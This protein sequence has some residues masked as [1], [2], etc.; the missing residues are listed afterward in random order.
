MFA[1][2]PTHMQRIS[3]EKAAAGHPAASAQRPVAK[4]YLF[5]VDQ[6]GLDIQPAASCPPEAVN[7]C[8]QLGPI[9]ARLPQTSGGN[10]GSGGLVVTACFLLHVCAA[11]TTKAVSPCRRSPPKV[12][13]ASSLHVGRP[14]D[15]VV[16][17]CLLG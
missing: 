4:T 13:Q 16:K 1:L 3:G 5:A 12:C 11:S 14:L 6:A 7:T 17:S 2:R 15:L 10:Y 8:R 9:R